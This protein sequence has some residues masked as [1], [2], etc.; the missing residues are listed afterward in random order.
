M[1]RLSGSTAEF[2]SIWRRRMFGDQ[3]C[4]MEEG[5]LVCN[6]QPAL[7]GWLIGKDMTVSAM[8][9]GQT[10]VT[11]HLPDQEDLIPGGYRVEKI[12]LDGQEAPAQNIFGESA[13]SIR[14]GA[15]SRVEVWIEK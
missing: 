1:A 7:P 2:L 10:K 15:V 13:E 11:Y 9:L 12:L 6:L 4:T 3:P 14:N 8:F 5:T